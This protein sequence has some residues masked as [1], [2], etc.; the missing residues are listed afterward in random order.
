[1]LGLFGFCFV[2]LGETFKVFDKNGE[3]CKN[4]IIS[5]ITNDKKAIV[6]CH[7]DKRHEFED[8]DYVTFQEV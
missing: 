6:T 1:M 8:D 7:E 5:A 4:T 3:D 2:D